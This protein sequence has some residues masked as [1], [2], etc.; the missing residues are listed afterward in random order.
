MIDQEL[1]SIEEIIL[2]RRAAVPLHAR[3]S[4]GIEYAGR[5]GTISAMAYAT[6][7]FSAGIFHEGRGHE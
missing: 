3:R 7:S 6:M 2:R 4:L 1:P 5:G